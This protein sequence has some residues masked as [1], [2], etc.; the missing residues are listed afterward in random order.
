MEIVQLR[1][2]LNQPVKL[3]FRDGEVVEAI[4]LGIDPDRDRD[5]TYEVR[6]VVRKGTPPA[7]GTEEGGTSVAKIDELADWEPL[8]K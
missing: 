6:K 4:L 1:K 7:R 3:S 5:L 2:R 8:S